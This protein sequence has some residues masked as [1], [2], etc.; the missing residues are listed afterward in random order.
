VIQ[1]LKT[2]IDTVVRHAVVHHLEEAE[3]LACDDDLGGDLAAYHGY[4]TVGVY[5]GGVELQ[6]PVI[7]IRSCRLAMPAIALIDALVGVGL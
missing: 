4:K 3:L 2:N 7:L 6:I 1:S 5:G